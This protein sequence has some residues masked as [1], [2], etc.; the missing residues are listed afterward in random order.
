MA[1]LVLLLAGVVLCSVFAIL[2]FMD[3]Q[4]IIAF[5]D[6]ALAF[7]DAFFFSRIYVNDLG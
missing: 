5:T 4:Y 7:A 3:G 2:D 6:F 1:A